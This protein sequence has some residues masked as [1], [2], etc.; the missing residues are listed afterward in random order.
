MIELRLETEIHAPPEEIFT[1]LVDFSGYDG[2]LPASSAY[3][4]LTDVSSDPV[5]MGTTWSEP[6]ASG[7]RHGTVTEFDPPR[8]V[9]F[10]QPMTLRPKALGVIDITVAMDLE[11]AGASTVVRR[12][13][14]L[15]L[16]WS[17]KPIRPYVARQ[18]REEG[19]RTL[20]ALKE[21]AERER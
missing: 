4:G 16:P 20:R 9:T 2:W 11:P 10:H 8:K 12:L 14:T 15:E 3:R 6:A 17:L 19:T 21:F 5:A 1:T 7:V 13:V 18:F